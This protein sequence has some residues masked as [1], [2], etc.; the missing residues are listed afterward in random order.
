MAIGDKQITE[1]YWANDGPAKIEVTYVDDSTN[2]KQ[3]LR[4]GGHI[5][6]DPSGGIKNSDL[7]AAQNAFSEALVMLRDKYPYVAP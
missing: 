4:L 1:R 2:A 7:L 5:E 3:E 6:L